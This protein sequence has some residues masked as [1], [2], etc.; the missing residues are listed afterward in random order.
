MK[1]LHTTVPEKV[2][3]FLMQE[4]GTDNIDNYIREVIERDMGDRK[5][6]GSRKQY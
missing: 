6:D 3:D 4:I 5:Y 1:K 2:F